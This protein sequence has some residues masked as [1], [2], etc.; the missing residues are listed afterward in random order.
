MTN[1]YHQAKNFAYTVVAVATI[2]S[3]TFVDSSYCT[4]N[5]VEME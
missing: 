3:D 5:S 2:H 1:S 4:E